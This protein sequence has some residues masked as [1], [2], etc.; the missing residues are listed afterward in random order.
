LFIY[1]EFISFLVF[2]ILI[3]KI[4]V[5]FQNEKINNLLEK[6]VNNNND[7]QNSIA[8][9]KKNIFNTSLLSA[10]L[11]DFAARESGAII[12]ESSKDCYNA[13]GMLE[14]DMDRY[15]YK[16]STK[17]SYLRCSTDGKDIHVTIRF[18]EDIQAVTF[19]LLNNEQY[20]ANIKQFS[21]FL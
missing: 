16:N 20:S 18:N 6:E 8:N 5:V 3:Y 21:V 13:G 1:F 17:N 11:H 15:F 19:M 12:V 9:L 14:N 10:K 2:F 7:Q 4:I